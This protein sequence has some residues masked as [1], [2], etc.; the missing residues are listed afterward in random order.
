MYTISGESLSPSPAKERDTQKACPFFWSR[1]REFEKEFKAAKTKREKEKNR[2]G[3]FRFLA[4]T[5]R[6]HGES[7]SPSPAKERDTQKACPFFWSR[8]REFEKIKAAKTKR[9]KEENRREL[10]RFLARTRRECGESLSPSPAKERDTQ[11]A[12]PFFWSRRRESDPP[13]SAW[14]ADA[15]PLGDACKNSVGIGDVCAESNLRSMKCFL[16]RRKSRLQSPFGRRERENGKR[17]VCFS[18]RE[19]DESALIHRM[20]RSAKQAI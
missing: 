5:R 14:E 11:K 18:E 9:E 4:R 17:Q 2:R 16:N 6:E 10:F 15:I 19:K 7:L 13:K 20:I 12:C 3:W 1:R 8:R